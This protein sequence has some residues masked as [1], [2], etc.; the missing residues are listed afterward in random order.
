MWLAGH[1]LFPITG[2]EPAPS[3]SHAK[4]LIMEGT[5]KSVNNDVWIFDAITILKNTRLMQLIMAS[6]VMFC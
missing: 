2:R 4:W 5:L 6:Q 1:W 3:W